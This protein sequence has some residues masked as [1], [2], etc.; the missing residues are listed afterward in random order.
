MGLQITKVADALAGTEYDAIN[1]EDVIQATLK[2]NKGRSV[3][4][5]TWR[6]RLWD[7]NGDAEITATAKLNTIA[8]K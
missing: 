3:N 4:P 5:I 8:N 1:D 7:K 2:L 6:V